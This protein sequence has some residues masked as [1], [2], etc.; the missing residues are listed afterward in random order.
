VRIEPRASFTT[1]LVALIFGLFSQ[2]AVAQTPV[3]QHPGIWVSQ[4]QLDYV[5]QQFAAGAQPFTAAINTAQGSIWGTLYGAQGSKA[6]VLNGT[7]YSDINGVSQKIPLIIPPQT[8]G[9][10][11]G[12]NISFGNALPIN[13][14]EGQVVCGS[15]TRTEP[16]TNPIGST[17]Q[18]IRVGCDEELNSASVAYT[19]ALLW[20]ITGNAQYATSAMEVMDYYSGYILNEPSGS[21]VTSMPTAVSFKGYVY[22]TYTASSS[23]GTGVYDYSV[24]D[25]LEEANKVFSNAPLQ[26]TWASP[27]WMAAAEILHSYQQSPGVTLNWPGYS[28]FVN[29]LTTYYY[30]P[31]L[32]HDA[33]YDDHNGNWILTLLDTRMSYSVLTEN[34]TIY[35]AAIAE[36]ELTVPAT[37]YSFA[38]DSG[39]KDLQGNPA[40]FTY[41]NG[42]SDTSSQSVTSGYGWNGQTIFNASTDGIGQETCRD[43]AHAQYSLSA[44][45]STAETAW[46]Q[47]NP[48]LYT[49]Q[50]ARLASAMEFQSAIQIAAINATGINNINQ[51]ASAAVKTSKL[52]A[53]YSGN[54]CLGGNA[55]SPGG[56][57]PIVKGTM[58][59]G[60]TALA[61]RLNVPLPNTIQYLVNNVRP[62]TDSLNWG[63]M[64]SPTKTGPN[65]QIANDRMGVFWETMTNASGPAYVAPVLPT[66]PANLTA[67]APSSTSITLSWTASTDSA[68]T[69]TGYNI[70]RNHVLIAT[71]PTPSFTDTSVVSSTLYNYIIYAV[72]A[73]HNQSLSSNSVFITTPS[74]GGTGTGPTAPSGLTATAVSST[75]VNLSWSASTDSSSA[76]TGYTITRNGAVI[77]T[78]SSTSY[79]DTT[80]GAST[81]YTY[82][83]T[84]T[85]AAGNTSPA[86]N[87]A[88]VTTPGAV[89]T[90]T[91]TNQ[92]MVEG[93]TVPPTA[94]TVS[95]NIQLTTNP[96]CKDAAQS[97]SVPGTYSIVCN[98][99]A[100]AGYTFDYINGTMNVTAAPQVITITATSQTM[101][102]GDSTPTPK[103][104]VSPSV[105]LTTKPGCV[106]SATSTTL[107]GQYQ[108]IT[109]SGAIKAGYTFTY[110]TGTLTITPLSVTIEARSQHMKVGKAV[111][112]LTYEVKPSSATLTTQP[113]CTTTPLATSSSPV[114]TYTINCSGAVGAGYTFVYDSANLTIEN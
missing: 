66:A 5:K 86:S 19:Q 1:F 38:Q 54:L 112:T 77:A 106:D 91:A 24:P 26:A 18:E 52:G 63:S 44:S 60:H 3:W 113:T 97:T 2:P 29:M 73:A 58:E 32:A 102:F 8:E 47:G 41:P 62:I 76:I 96:V 14:I 33:Y 109:C 88:T 50:Q 6:D 71:S 16:G 9:T 82:T 42:P 114:G 64:V 46:I 61:T 59:K 43:A 55:N 108:S 30:T 103:Y 12:N 93:A 56:Y 11:Y 27:Q 36:W 79:S 22:T 7:A 104:T 110:V 74:T 10:T 98:G 37:Y 35:N 95:P 87:A 13:V 68:S 40:P 111:P 51:A 67:L 4:A 57:V 49:S 78:S 34:P 90:I 69:I 89:I 17:P 81:T 20:A 45:S 53:P 15:G 100:L 21:P 105:S 101:T 85:D 92:T 94:Y 107:P 31:W 80:V 48:E 65:N 83:V 23:S 84:A 39:F 28:A 70:Y 72:D 25:N 99:A 75:L